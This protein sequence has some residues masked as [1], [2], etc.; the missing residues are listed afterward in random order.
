MTRPRPL[1]ACVHGHLEPVA[2]PKRDNRLGNHRM[3]G[4]EAEPPSLRKG[5]QDEHHL[6]PGKRLADAPPGAGAERKVRA[7]RQ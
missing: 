7:R 4:H 1:A 2:Q 6:H 5:A 3:S